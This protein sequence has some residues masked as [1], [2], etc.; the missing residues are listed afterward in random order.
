[1]Q[2]VDFLVRAELPGRLWNGG[3][4]AGYLIWR[5]SPEKYK[6]FTDNRYDIWGGEFIRQ[7]HSVLGGWTAEFLD[8]NRWD[9]VDGFYPWDEV[10]DRWDAQ[11]LL[12]PS[13]ARVNAAL[14]ADGWVRVWEDLQWRIWVRDR[15]A[16]QVAI[17]RARALPRPDPWLKI[18]QFNGADAEPA[19]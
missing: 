3:N 19:R 1:M 12:L 11:T 7:E 16:N 10:L 2:A 15:A 9:R 18:L 13:E 8:S 6:V 5:L 14:S 17:A 4:Y